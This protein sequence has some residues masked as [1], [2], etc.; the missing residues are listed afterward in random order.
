MATATVR[1]TKSLVFFVVLNCG[2][3]CSCIR[4]FAFKEARC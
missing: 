1:G 2:C 4:V 3:V